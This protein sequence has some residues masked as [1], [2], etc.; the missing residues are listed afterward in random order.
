MRV[1]HDH[2]VIFVMFASSLFGQ[3]NAPK[4]VKPVPK[5]GVIS[6]RVFGIT[7]SG[8]IEPARMA[9]LYIMPIFTFHS[10]SEGTSIAMLWLETVSSGNKEMS[11]AHKRQGAEWGNEITC[12]EEL[13][14]YDDAYKKVLQWAIDNHRPYDVLIGDADEEGNFK[15]TVPL[16]GSYI[17][18]AKGR[19]GFTDAIWVE[20]HVWVEAGK[21]TTV[22]LSA[23]ERACLGDTQ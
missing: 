18:V 19:A 4:P 11:D 23:P 9:K 20:S 8:D 7:K 21:L 12:G 6:G 5:P 22:K 1:K 13:S 14:I 2:L 16:P 15:I 10:S 17:L 3:N